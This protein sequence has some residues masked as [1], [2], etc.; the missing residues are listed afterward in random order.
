MARQIRDDGGKVAADEPV[1]L[2]SSSCAAKPRVPDP[3][4]RRKRQSLGRR[5][6]RRG[7]QLGGLE[8]ALVGATRGWLPF[9][10]SATA[11]GVV[12]EGGKR[13][14]ARGQGGRRDVTT[15]EKG[16]QHK[17]VRTGKALRV[18]AARPSEG[19]A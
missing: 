6:N 15:C 16:K 7:L 10:F 18:S 11:E 9:D 8:V 3:L 4:N 5:I 2:N 19:G 1:H 14:S 17:F 13:R 12:M